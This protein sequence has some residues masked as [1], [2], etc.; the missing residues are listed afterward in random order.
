M[1]KLTTY[2]G[3]YG[4]PTESFDAA[5]TQETAISFLGKTIPVTLQPNVRNLYGAEEV[6]RVL[7]PRPEDVIGHV[8]FTSMRTSNDND[9][10]FKA[11]V[12]LN[13]PVVDDSLV[14]FSIRT[15]NKCGA[16]NGELQKIVTDIVSVD[17]CGEKYQGH[18]FERELYRVNNTEELSFS[19]LVKE[20][21]NK[22]ITLVSGDTLLVDYL[23]VYP[24]GEIW[25]MS[26]QKE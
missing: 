19:E 10:L 26:S 18:L 9:I 11:D 16:A 1:V 3:P 14:K 6:K 20:H 12:H 21:V 23:K 22:E 25:A 5:L 7:T 15:V 17:M 24:T 2:I 8:R 13:E 4:A